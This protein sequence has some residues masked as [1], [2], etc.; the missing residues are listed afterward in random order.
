MRI[1]KMRWSNNSKCF[2]DGI[3]TFYG[4]INGRIH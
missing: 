1:V 4:I 3:G 2:F